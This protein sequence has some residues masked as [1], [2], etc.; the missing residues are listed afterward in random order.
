MG[1]QE[2]A[3]RKHLKTKRRPNSHRTRL[4]KALAGKA[5][6]PFPMASPTKAFEKEKLSACP[7]DPAPRKHLKAK[8]RPRSHR[9]RP[10]ESIC[11]ELRRPECAPI[12]TGPG[13]TKAFT[14]NSSTRLPGPPH[15]I[16]LKEKPSYCPH[17]PAPRKHLKTKHV[18]IPTG[19]KQLLL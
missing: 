1:P 16:I 7:Q 6:P 2:P 4:T 9:T 10:H 12:R 17:N 13:A 8:R 15:E 18:P 5:A 14:G 11:K 3:P 19:P